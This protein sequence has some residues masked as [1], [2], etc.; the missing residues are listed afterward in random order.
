MHLLVPVFGRLRFTVCVCVVALRCCPSLTMLGLSNDASLA[1]AQTVQLGRCGGVD[2]QVPPLLLFS[3]ALAGCRCFAPRAVLYAVNSRPCMLAWHLRCMLDEVDQYAADGVCM[4]QQEVGA[5]AYRCFGMLSR[6]FWF[7]KNVS[8]FL[9][10]AWSLGCMWPW[11]CLIYGWFC[12]MPC[13]MPIYHIC[14]GTVHYQPVCVCLCT[15]CALSGTLPCTLLVCCT[16]KD[17]M[18]FCARRRPACPSSVL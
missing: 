15:P 18:P 6:R 4:Q 14:V 13:A 9:A 16:H 3:A 1:A 12:C 5:A 17:A 7:L 10:S 8:V 11:R 2:L